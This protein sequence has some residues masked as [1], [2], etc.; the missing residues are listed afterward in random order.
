MPRTMTRRT[1]CTKDWLLALGITA[2]YAVVAL[3]NL[4]STK[5]PESVAHA[6]SRGKRD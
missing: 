1:E 5:V 3:I 6:D 4:G 2:V